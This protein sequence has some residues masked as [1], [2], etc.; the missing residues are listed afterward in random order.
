MFVNLHGICAYDAMN[1]MK[2]VTIAK[3]M[4]RT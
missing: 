2:Y 1:M 3:T 4:F